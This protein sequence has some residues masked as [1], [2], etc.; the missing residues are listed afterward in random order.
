MSEKSYYLSMQKTDHNL[1]FIASF[2]AGFLEAVTASLS[3]DL[4]RK[5]KILLS[6]DGFIV[7]ESSI[8]PRKIKKLPYL[9]NVYICL[10]QLSEKKQLQ[11]DDFVEKMLLTS[12]DFRIHTHTSERINTFR[13]MVS[14]SGKLTQISRKTRS[15]FIGK[16]TAETGLRYSSDRADCEYWIIRRKSGNGFLCRRMKTR[17]KTEKNLQKGELRPEIAHLL[18]IL[19]EPAETD[20]FLDPFSGTGAIPFA[21]ARMKYN[22]IFAFDTDQNRVSAMKT[23]L[24]KNRSV[25]ENKKHPLIVRCED[26]RKMCSISDGFIDRIVTDPPWGIFDDSKQYDSVFYQEIFREMIRIL[27]PEGIIVML[28]GN[29]EEAE[30]IWNCSAELEQKIFID[31]LISG[32]KACVMKWKKRA[33]Q[34]V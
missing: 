34:E 4:D 21:R 2:P 6:E 11:I 25:S 16:V 8:T 17:E 1:I 3:H 31:V 24:K 23:F 10:K 32:R 33:F 15:M 5:I 30:K 13:I 29:R 20:I 7:F 18:C 9:N 22:M 12:T 26:A 19:S 27:K 14:D 28:L